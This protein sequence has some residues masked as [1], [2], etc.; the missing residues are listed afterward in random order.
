MN[1]DTGDRA[2]ALRHEVAGAK[3]NQPQLIEQPPG[4]VAPKKL[5]LDRET[6]RAIKIKKP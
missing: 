5:L 4:K 3:G 1:Q 6:S 2:A